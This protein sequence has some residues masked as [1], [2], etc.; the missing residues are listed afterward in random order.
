MG[1]WGEVMLRLGQDI[2][3]HHV[4]N[5]T[6]IHMY[7]EGWV[8]FNQVECL[9]HICPGRRWDR[10]AMRTE[11]LKILVTHWPLGDVGIILNVQSRNTRHRLSSWAIPVKLLSG[12]CHRTAWMTSEHWLVLSVRLT[13][14][15]KP[16]PERMLPNIYVTRW[17]HCV[18][19][20]SLSKHS[21][22]SHFPW[23]PLPI[24]P[25]QF[26]TRKL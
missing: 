7:T 21:N 18:T 1:A 13:G 25:N 22:R 11:G 4:H 6:N 8:C 24:M 12:E 9:A 10:D 16:L 23:N 20:H 2:R 17:H 19:M 14:S 15:T 26:A 5:H 3:L